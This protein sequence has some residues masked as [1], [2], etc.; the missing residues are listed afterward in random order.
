[1]Q[2]LL[3]RTFAGRSVMCMQGRVHP[4]EGRSLAE[5]ALPIRV[6][7][8]LGCNIVLMTSAVGGINK[9]YARGDLMVLDDHIF[10]PGMAL[11]S[12]LVGP[13]EHR[14]VAIVADTCTCTH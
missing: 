4:Y 5:C 7:S 11:R 3:T 8:L 6:A 2:T 14:Y 1:V 9:T 12:P 13:N 10:V